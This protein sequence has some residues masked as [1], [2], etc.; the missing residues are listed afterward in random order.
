MKGTGNI[1]HRGL[2]SHGESLRMQCLLARSHK[3]KAVWL[4]T[5]LLFA[6]IM[7]QLTVSFRQSLRTLEFQA[8]STISSWVGK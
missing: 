3:I 4:I 1:A 2:Y 5:V 7:Q 8:S 6:F